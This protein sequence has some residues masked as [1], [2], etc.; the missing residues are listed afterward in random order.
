MSGHQ[1]LTM[2]VL[3]G[4]LGGF[5][6]GVGRLP[7]PWQALLLSISIYVALRC[8]GGGYLSRDGLSAQRR[9]LV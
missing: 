9:S 8:A 1:L 3:Y 7:V 6:L 5:L 2:L 4:V